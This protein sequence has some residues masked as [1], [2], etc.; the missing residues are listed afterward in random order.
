DGE[1]YRRYITSLQSKF[2]KLAERVNSK[3]TTFE[4]W[5]PDRIEE[6]LNQVLS[7]DDSA[8][9]FG[10]VQGG[11]TNDLEATFDDLY[12][13]LVEIYLPQDENES[14]NEAEV[15]SI[16]SRSLRERN[17][18]RLLR[19]AVIHTEK[20]DFE[21]EHA[22][23]NG[24]WKALEPLS[25]DLINPGSIRRKALQ[26][27]GQNVVLEASKDIGLLYYL[28][29]QPRRDDKAVLKEYAKAKDLLGTGKHS[30]KIRLIEEDEA[31]DFARDIA[32]RIEADTSHDKS[33]K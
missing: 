11:M 18:T 29:G 4:P 19:P 7:P 32:P 12:R 16:F 26:Y 10:E 15:W 28:L 25:F 24:H 5:L 3:Q 8:I 20:Q 9:Q 2:N 23:K 22:W 27:F 6:L 21:F 1:F 33:K 13:R 31:E 30:K 17:V 14:R